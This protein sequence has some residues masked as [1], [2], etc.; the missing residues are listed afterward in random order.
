MADLF[1]TVIH[2]DTFGDAISGKDLRA[3]RTDL[4]GG[5]TGDVYQLIEQGNTGVYVSGAIA[6]ISTPVDADS[7]Q[8]GNFEIWEYAGGAPLSQVVANYSIGASSGVL[9]LIY[10]TN[11]DLANKADANHNHDDRYYT[12]TEVD[13]FLSD[14]ADA[15]HNHDSAYYT[16]TQV[17]GFLSGKS[18]VGHTHTEYLTESQI[19][20]ALSSKNV[21]PS[22]ILQINPN[23][24]FLSLKDLDSNK[25]SIPAFYGQQDSAKVLQE[26][27]LGIDLTGALA[28]GTYIKDVNQNLGNTSAVVDQK[29]VGCLIYFQPYDTVY[30]VISVGWDST[31]ECV[32]F[33]VDTD[34]SFGNDTGTAN[35]F[36]GSFY[37]L[38]VTP[39]LNGVLSNDLAQH[40]LLY[41]SQQGQ[42]LS[43]KLL[44]DLNRQYKIESFGVSNGEVSDE[45]REVTFTPS[46]SLGTIQNDNFTLT[47]AEFGITVNI[48]KIGD[49]ANAD[50]FEICWNVGSPAS[51]ANENHRKI[52]TYATVF[53]IALADAQ[54]VYVSVRPLK[55]GVVLTDTINKMIRSGAG[56]AISE[57]RSTHVDVDIATS[58]TSQA[59]RTVLQKAFKSPVKILQA[60]FVATGS[61]VGVSKFRI[62]QS[63]LSSNIVSAQFTDDDS[64]NIQYSP[65]N[66]NLD[67]NLEGGVYEITADFYDP[68]GSNNTAIAGRLEIFYRDI[69]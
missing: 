45:K 57:I 38:K 36:S 40:I 52:L 22:P 32:M 37:Y 30:R 18:D 16:Q 14:K 63:N 21:A 55:N 20:E 54:D 61:T 29:W 2:Q 7:A 23:A 31:I 50:A 64:L 10:D 53:D 59:A 60:T 58:D 68:A 19:R 65:A 28:T 25:I 26:I 33:G 46:Y 27:T 3:R 1:I 66:L 41:T 44:L 4:T 67:I 17:D 11:Q 5:Y 56:G 12:E 15:N 35:I 8:I 13:N 49:W 43:Y 62:F 24:E 34:T 42:P 48:S 9:Q 47:S 39:Y 6:D 51:F 69:K